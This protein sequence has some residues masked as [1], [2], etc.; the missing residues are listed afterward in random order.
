MATLKKLPGGTR[1]WSEK[2][3]VAV[4]LGLLALGGVV[5]APIIGLFGKDDKSKA[6]AGNPAATMSGVT[7]S[8]QGNS[9]T[10]NLGTI[11]QNP[12]LAPP[13]VLASAREK[14]SVN[15]AASDAEDD[16]TI[17]KRPG[18][19][20]YVISKRDAV[21]VVSR[22]PS[23]DETFATAMGNRPGV[24][25]D[26]IAKLTARYFAGM[27]GFS[28]L[29]ILD[30]KLVNN[31]DETVFFSDLLFSEI[32]SIPDNRPELQW[33]RVVYAEYNPTC[34]WYIKNDGWGPAEDAVLTIRATKPFKLGEDDE[35]AMQ[36]A[37]TSARPVRYQ[38]G[39]IDREATISLLPLVG[40]SNGQKSISFTD[41]IKVE[42]ELEFSFHDLDGSV[43]KAKLPVFLTIHGWSPA[44]GVPVPPSMSYDAKL[45]VDGKGYEVRTQ[46]S[47]ALA[48]REAGRF[49]VVV[50]ADQ[51]SVHLFKLKLRYNDDQILDLGPYELQ[52]YLPRSE[53]NRSK[54]AEKNLSPN[55]PLPA[56]LPMKLAPLDPPPAEHRP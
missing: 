22:R 5:A 36:R 1:K 39:Q 29:P 21:S 20:A 12:V 49:T 32:T 2:S 33:R 15:V 50:S 10:Q 9:V 13:K 28:G 30:F 19:R 46:V 48:P 38:I 51:S 11:Y 24:S 18:P 25:K 4:L 14:V 47:E 37:L 3:K 34:E 17:A 16:G 7:V 26:E 23:V 54:P 43:Q 55:P 53:A 31:T 52:F 56:V 41:T 6:P 35:D 8:G 45:A 40:E 44:P 42:G 27:D